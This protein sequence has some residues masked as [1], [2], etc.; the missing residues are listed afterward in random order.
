MLIKILPV[1][2]VARL[3]S[4]DTNYSFIILEHSKAYNKNDLHTMHVY[5]KILSDRFLK[6]SVFHKQ[7]I[8]TKSVNYIFDQ[9]KS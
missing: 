6:K 2:L 7:S 4:S 1:M 3:Q 9:K 8:H 5:F